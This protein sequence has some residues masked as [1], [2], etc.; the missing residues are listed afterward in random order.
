MKRF[1]V[2]GLG[3]FGMDLVKELSGEGVELIAIDRKAQLVN[4]VVNLV[5][6]AVA[7]DA[8][9]KNALIEH[10]L[11]DVDV[12]VVSIGEDFESNILT[13]LLLKEIGVKNVIARAMSKTQANILQHLGIDEI[14][15]PEEDAAHRLAKRLARPNLM[16]F[17]EL[18]EHHVIV[19]MKAPP[20]FVGKSLIDL[21]IRRRYNVNLVAIKRGKKGSKD[22]INVPHAEDVIEQDDV[23]LVV[24]RDKNVDLMAKH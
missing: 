12:A 16:D 17:I 14:I 8:T 7:F 2:I 21:D 19:Q 11:R 4:E 3:R 20:H 22:I 13:A 9:N 23:L 24:G 15:N 5:A 10:G 1:A 6:V 18:A